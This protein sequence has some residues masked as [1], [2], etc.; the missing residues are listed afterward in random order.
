MTRS[1]V[2]L[3]AQWATYRER[4]S[5]VHR[6]LGISNDH[7]QSRRL[8]LYWES[9]ALVNAGH[10]YIG[11]DVFLTKRTA[12]AW[13]Q[14]RDAASSEGITLLPV[15]GFRSVQRQQEI[16][17]A[18]LTKGIPLLEVLQV[19][20]APGYSQHHSG[21]AIDITD[22][23]TRNRP[24]NEDFEFQP[25]FRWLVEHASRFGFRMEYP[26]GNVYGFI[27]EPWHW[28]FNEVD[29]LTFFQGEIQ[30]NS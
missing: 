5:A 29:E 6:S 21:C 26:R 1:K 7:A 30:N 23:E 9:S 8:P 13:N 20:A 10:D 16:I 28:V 25:A 27:Y 18:K 3:E 19:N 22:S 4:I 12:D 2:D 15:S 11:R 17:S 24:L 14:M